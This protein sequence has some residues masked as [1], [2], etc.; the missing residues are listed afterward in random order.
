MVSLLIDGPVT[1][2][3][4]HRLVIVELSKI[5][6]SKILEIMDLEIQRHTKLKVLLPGT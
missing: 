5:L 3:E 2:S 1:A 4:I 6:F